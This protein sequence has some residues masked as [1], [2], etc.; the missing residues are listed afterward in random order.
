MKSI[1][2]FLFIAFAFSASSIFAAEAPEPTFSIWGEPVS[3]PLDYYNLIKNQTGQEFTG[4][5]ISCIDG[6]SG[7]N[8]SFVLK[9]QV[10]NAANGALRYEINPSIDSPNNS[11]GFQECT[12]ASLGFGVATSE[13][14]RII[15]FGM[16]EANSAVIHGYNAETGAKLYD[17]SFPRVDG[18]YTLATP[19]NQGEWSAVGNFL[20]DRSDQI[21]VSYIKGSVSPGPVDIK[22][23]YFNVLTGVQIG[24]PIIMSVPTPSLP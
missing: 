15:V 23:T 1:A 17:I 6:G 19:G 14:K 22:V 4:Y 16:T 2:R 9:V 18:E 3:G 10:F 7:S 13:K 12:F 5:T 8:D 24:N 20:N 11:P 21:R